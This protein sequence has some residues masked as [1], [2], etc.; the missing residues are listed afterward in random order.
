MK[1]LL[2]L[3]QRLFS[4]GNHSKSSSGNTKLEDGMNIFKMSYDIDKVKQGEYIKELDES[5][6]Y[7]L[8]KQLVRSDQR[9]EKE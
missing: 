9:G 5:V 6:E 2:D 1:H 8:T 3:R 4:F 7:L